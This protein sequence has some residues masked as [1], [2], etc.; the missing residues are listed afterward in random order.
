MQRWQETKDRLYDQLLPGWQEFICRDAQAA[1]WIADQEGKLRAA[2]EAGNEMQYERAAATWRRAWERVNERLAESYRRAHP[3][4]EEWDLRFVK[5]M[6]EVIHIKFAAPGGR[7][8]LV[9]RQVP[10]ELDGQRCYTVDQMIGLLH[11]TALTIAEV[12]E[13]SPIPEQIPSPPGPGEKHLVVDLTGTTPKISYRW[14][15]L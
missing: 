5:W 13:Q 14:G 1:R 2:L 15:E 11:P 7:F 4:P 6:A 10:A 9:P 3:A 12:F 8:Y